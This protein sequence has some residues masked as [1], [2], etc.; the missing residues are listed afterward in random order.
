VIAGEEAGSKLERARE[1]GIRIVDP[2]EF[3]R[4]LAGS[5]DLG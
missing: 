2:D 5:T 3:E 4:L 1:L